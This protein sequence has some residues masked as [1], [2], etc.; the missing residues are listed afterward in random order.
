MD[1]RKNVTGFA[2]ISETKKIELALEL[3]VKLMNSHG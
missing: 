3:L 2:N 1:Y